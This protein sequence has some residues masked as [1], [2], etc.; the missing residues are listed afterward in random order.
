MRAKAIVTRSKMLVR[1]S[2]FAGSSSEQLQ[3]H[4]YRLMRHNQL[5]RS[6]KTRLGESVKCKATDMLQGLDCTASN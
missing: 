6:T 3:Q 2:A 5:E 4:T 1:C